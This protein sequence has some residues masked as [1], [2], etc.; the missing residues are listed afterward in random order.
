MNSWFRHCIYFPP[1]NLSS[2]DRPYRILACITAYNDIDAVDT[3][4]TL[5][6]K[7]SYPINAYLIIDNSNPP[8]I[9]NCNF[10]QYCC[11]SSPEIVICSHP[12]NIGTAGALC[13]QIE[14]AIAHDFDFVWL[15]D[16]DSQPEVD[17]L[18]KLLSHYQQL[19]Q[20]G[21]NAGIIAPLPIDPRTSYELHGLEFDRYRF[22]SVSKAKMLKSMYNCDAV[23]ASGSLISLK[24]AKKVKLP[25]KQLFIDAV[26]WAYCLNFRQ[27]GY[28]IFL[29]RETRLIHHYSNSKKIVL[30]FFYHSF[31]V[32]QY[33]AL[34]R[35]YICR[36]HTFVELTYCDRHYY[37][38]V[39]FHRIL[40]LFK[41]LLKIWLYEDHRLRK[42][43]A[44]LL[45]TYDGFVGRLGK[46]W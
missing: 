28:E 10:Q 40:T 25:D 9:E 41:T 2:T 18:Q 1:C 38:W 39:F 3:C 5:L 19:T 36:N 34:R 8:L 24:A 45:G 13:H 35:Y 16:Q 11:D 14:W 26:D 37:I 22:V 31:L 21:H 42:T 33:S 6:R 27:K 46:R 32:H 29:I 12:E 44:C 23:I 30:P 43:W 7:Q 4:F 20:E 17:C 15:F